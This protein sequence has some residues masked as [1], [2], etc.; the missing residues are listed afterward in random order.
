MSK[1][2]LGCVGLKLPLTNIDISV[3][4]CFGLLGP[5]SSPAWACTLPKTDFG[6]SVQIVF[7]LFGPNSNSKHISTSVLKSP[8][9]CL[10][11][12]MYQNRFRHQC[13]NLFWVALLG[14]TNSPKQISTAVS[15]S[16]VGCLVLKLPKRSPKHMWPDPGIHLAAQRPVSDATKLPE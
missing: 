1:S 15:K 14:H 8:W 3:E 5:Q 6:I 2:V 9:G 13:R 10:G 12:E 7:G 4:I 11:S 16:A